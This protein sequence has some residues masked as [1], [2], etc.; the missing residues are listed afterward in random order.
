MCEQ[1]LVVG[2]GEGPAMSLG[3]GSEKPQSHHTERKP[4]RTI[5]SKFIGVPPN[6]SP[7]LFVP[8]GRGEG[9]LV[10]SNSFEHA[11]WDLRFFFFVV[12]GP[13]KAQLVV[14]AWQ[15]TG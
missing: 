11:Q 14:W 13:Y 8:L 12:G 9:C 15:L 2:E 4:A 10:T 6:Q 3:K 1:I 5:S 7:Y